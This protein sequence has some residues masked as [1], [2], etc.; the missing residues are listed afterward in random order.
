MIHV[1]EH[2][3]IIRSYRHII[4]PCDLGN[5]ATFDLVW[6]KGSGMTPVETNFYKIS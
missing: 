3:I 4:T 6:L 5:M 2:T 1:D